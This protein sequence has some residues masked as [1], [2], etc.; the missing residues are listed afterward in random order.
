MK[1]SV[2]TLIVLLFIGCGKAPPATPLGTLGISAVL[3]AGAQVKTLE[4]NLVYRIEWSDPD[5]Q[6]RR[7]MVS[8]LA[9]DGNFSDNLV[10]AL[11]EYESAIRAGNAKVKKISETR[12][13]S[14]AHRVVYRTELADRH[15]SQSTSQ[16]FIGRKVV[17]VILVHPGAEEPSASQKAL[18]DSVRGF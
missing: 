3:P 2:S 10:P 12:I 7:A 6:Q 15:D 9:I 5:G 13:D 4:E 11:A 1:F 14:N 16:V 17:E 8:L 18:A